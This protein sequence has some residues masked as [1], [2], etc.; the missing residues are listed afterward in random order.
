MGPPDLVSRTHTF[1]DSEMGSLYGSR[2]PQGVPLGVP[3]FSAKVFFSTNR[4]S[5]IRSTGPSIFPSS[6]SLTALDGV[7][8]MVEMK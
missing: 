6:A 2:L 4:P 3:G 1:R 7:D 8:L 5:P